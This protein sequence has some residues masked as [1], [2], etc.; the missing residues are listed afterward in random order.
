MAVTRKTSRFTV[1][2]PPKVREQMREAGDGIPDGRR[3]R[4]LLE[5]WADDQDLQRRVREAHSRLYRLRHK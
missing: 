5:L 3:A 4:L 1:D 2:V